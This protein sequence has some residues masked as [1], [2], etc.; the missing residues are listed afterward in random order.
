MS[1]GLIMK[2]SNVFILVVS[3]MIINNP[4]LADYLLQKHINKT[5]FHVDQFDFTPLTNE[6]GTGGETGE[7]GSGTELSSL[8]P[9]RVG[10]IQIH[11]FGYD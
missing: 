7:T 6:T 10:N 3:L 8:T 9:V 11:N 2:S 1:K 4:L 5:G